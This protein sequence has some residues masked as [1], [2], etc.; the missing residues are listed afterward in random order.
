MYMSGYTD[1]EVLAHGVKLGEVELIEKP[2]RRHVLAAKMHEIL[3]RTPSLAER[4]VA[5]PARVR[6]GAR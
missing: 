3:D 6:L 2:F 5:R 4:P 1:D